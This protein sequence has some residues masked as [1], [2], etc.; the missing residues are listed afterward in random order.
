M[1]MQSAFS[2]FGQVYIFTES[3]VIDLLFSNIKPTDFHYVLE[4]CYLS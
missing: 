2:L 1:R 3:L 4:A